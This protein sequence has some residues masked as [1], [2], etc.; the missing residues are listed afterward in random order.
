MIHLTQ[1]LLPQLVDG[2]E[3]DD[4]RHTE[5]GLGAVLLGATL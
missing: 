2:L 5:V 1:V 3:I 4:A